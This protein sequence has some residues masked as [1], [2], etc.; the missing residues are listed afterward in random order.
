MT[1]GRAGCRFRV[2]L[3]AWDVSSKSGPAGR[4]EISEWLENML[5]S[6]VW[7][8]EI[9]WT[10]GLKQCPWQFSHQPVWHE[11]VR[12]LLCQVVGGNHSYSLKLA[13]AEYFCHKIWHPNHCKHLQRA[14]YK[15]FSL[16]FVD[17]SHRVHVGRWFTWDF[18]VGSGCFARDQKNAAKKLEKLGEFFD[19]Q[20]VRPFPTPSFKLAAWSPHRCSMSDFFWP[21]E[22]Q[23]IPFVSCGQIKW[24][25]CFIG[26]KD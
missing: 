17:M 21:N 18:E 26:A 19:A 15:S 16:Y 12:C 25:Y 24:H 4:D 13:F 6:A 10:F 3:G 20:M 8:F 7:E 5:V 11:A 9:I 1:R 23:G 2:S 14:F 22:N